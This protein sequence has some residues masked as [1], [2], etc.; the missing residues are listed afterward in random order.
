MTYQCALA[1][2]KVTLIVLAETTISEFMIAAGHLWKPIAGVIVP[3]IA[4]EPFWMT[5]VPPVVLDT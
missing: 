1:K 5:S 4:V 3:D 2:K